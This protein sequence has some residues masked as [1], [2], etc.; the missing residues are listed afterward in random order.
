MLCVGAGLKLEFGLA[1]NFVVGGCG[2]GSSLW[3]VLS[4]LCGCILLCFVRWVVFL[5]LCF[6][7]LYCDRLFERAIMWLVLC[8]LLFS[9]VVASGLCT[10]SW[11]DFSF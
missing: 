9:V 11:F 10:G 2:L 7:G 1:I 3:L 4:V 6:G 8:G 5:L